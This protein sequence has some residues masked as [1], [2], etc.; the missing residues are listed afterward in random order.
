MKV[1]VSLTHQQQQVLAGLAE[2]Y[3]PPL[4]LEYEFAS[5]VAHH[6]SCAEIQAEAIRAWRLTPDDVHDPLNLWL[7]SGA[8]GGELWWRAARTRPGDHVELLAHTGVLVSLNPCGD[9]LF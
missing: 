6:T 8:E 4:S 7:E 9:D 2:R 5:G 3:D 1:T